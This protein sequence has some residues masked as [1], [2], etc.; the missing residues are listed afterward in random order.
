MSNP[1]N[2]NLTDDVEIEIKLNKFVLRWYQLDAWNAIMEGKTKR[3]L[4]ISPRRS[5]KDFLCWNIAIR[6]CI[7]KTCLVFYVL[8]TYSQARKAIWDAIAI[9]GTKFLDYIPK[10][11]VE[12]IN[13]SDMKVRFKNGSILQCISGDSYDTSIVGTNPYAVILSEFALMPSEIFAYI[14][15][16]LAANG[17]WCIINSTPRGKNHLWH[18]Y[19]TAQELP[20]GS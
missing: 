8:P 7:R 17:G 11:L 18:L 14:R 3:L 5:G 15:P 2:R 19:K 9:D 16:I 4:L 12:S 1:E 20:I 13:Q 10:E 6:Q